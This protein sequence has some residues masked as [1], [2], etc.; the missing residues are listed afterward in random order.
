[1]VS[2]IGDSNST[3]NVEKWSGVSNCQCSHESVPSVSATRTSPCV[4]TLASCLFRPGAVG[5]LGQSESSGGSRPPLT[6]KTTLELLKYVW[7]TA[8]KKK[9]ELLQFSAVFFALM[10]SLLVV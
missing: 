2:A 10:S 3:D 4:E 1:M 9:K 5:S 6:P 7:D 8:M